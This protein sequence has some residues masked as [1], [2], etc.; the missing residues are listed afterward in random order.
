MVYARYIKIT[1]EKKTYMITYM[2]YMVNNYTWQS[3]RS[4]S[5]R[6]MSL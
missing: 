6:S 2:T 1:Y 4:I 3:K 5:S